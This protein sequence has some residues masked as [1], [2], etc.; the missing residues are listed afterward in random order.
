ML[1]NLK[2]IAII[3][4]PI[5]L[6]G[7]AWYSYSKGRALGMS[8]IQTLWDAERAATMAAQAEEMMKARQREQALQALVDKQRRAHDAEVKRVVREYGALVDGLRDRPEARAGAGGVPEGAAAGTGCTGAGLAGP[9]ARFLAGYAADAAR[10]QL[11][12]DACKVAY[13]EVRRAVNGDQ[14]P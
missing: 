7:T 4:I 13:D 9:D 11:A 5:L 10:L 6:A 3:T 1:W 8:Q 12:L 14:T 2:L